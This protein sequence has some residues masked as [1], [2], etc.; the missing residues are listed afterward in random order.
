ML[1]RQDL[2]V[3]VMRDR[4]RDKIIRPIKEKNC[5]SIKLLE[6]LDRAEAQKNLEHR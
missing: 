2:Q 1:G 4:C 5:L 6:E 3:V